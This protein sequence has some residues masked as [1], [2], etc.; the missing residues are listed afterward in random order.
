MRES[1]NAEIDEER[2]SRRSA[3]STAERRRV[4]SVE[5]SEEERQNGKPRVREPKTLV[6]IAGLSE[7]TE[8]NDIGR[9]LEQ[10][11]DIDWIRVLKERNGRSRGMAHC[12]FDLVSTAEQVIGLSE[13]IE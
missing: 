7:D 3:G 1:F 11:G 8:E 12:E 4:E 9:V 13:Q 10:Y 5:E 6:L 2:R